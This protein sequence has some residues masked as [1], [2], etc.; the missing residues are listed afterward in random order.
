MSW[1]QSCVKRCLSPGGE[2]PRPPGYSQS[3]S[4]PSKPYWR[5]KEMEDSMKFL[6]LESSFTM[7]ENLP[8]ERIVSINKL[9]YLEKLFI[10]KPYHNL[11]WHS[12]WINIGMKKYRSHNRGKNLKNFFICKHKESTILYPLN[13]QGQVISSGRFDLFIVLDHTEYR[14]PCSLV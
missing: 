2:F 4:N 11:I 5:S 7:T 3:K 9:K 14:D 12:F 1:A 8:D 13:C 6:R 10:G